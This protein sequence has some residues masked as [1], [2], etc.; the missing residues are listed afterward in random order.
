[1]R[2]LLLACLLFAVPFATGCGGG[3]PGKNKNY[4]RPTTSK[5]TE[6]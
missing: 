1:V 5:R 4:D 3:E 2:R 6:K